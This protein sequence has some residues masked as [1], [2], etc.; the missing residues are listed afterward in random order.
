M[1]IVRLGKPTDKR[2]DYPVW[3]RR[4]KENTEIMRRSEGN[5]D[6]FCSA[7]D[8]RMSKESRDLAGTAGRSL[9]TQSRILQRTPEWSEPDKSISIYLDSNVRLLLVPLSELY[10]QLESRTP[11]T[12]S[13]ASNE[14][15]TSKAK[16]RGTPS[17]TK[18]NPT[19]EP[20]AT[21]TDPQPTFAVDNRA[22]K[23]FRTLFFTPSITTMPGEVAWTNFVHAMASAGFAAEKLYGSVWHF[24]PSKI[25]VERSIQFHEPHPSV[26]IPF[27]T[28]RRHGRRLNRAYRWHGQVFVLQDKSAALPLNPDAAPTRAP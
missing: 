14:V 21:P 12:L 18:A 5:L 26:K 27:R 2:F 13:R 25:D 1:I 11:R 28:A 19:V 16:T 4:T 20:G 24:T 7:I 17:S 15:P 6:A 10:F 22:L 23:V 9:L 3:K 8:A